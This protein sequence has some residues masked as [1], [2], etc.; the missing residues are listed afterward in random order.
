ME[1]E[2][3]RG[4]NIHLHFLHPRPEH[5]I[6]GGGTSAQFKQRFPDLKIQERVGV[7]VGG[8]LYSRCENSEELL[9]RL[10]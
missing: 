4:I 3:P 8:S 9:M 2:T 6:L 7:N 10:V 1:T 5:M